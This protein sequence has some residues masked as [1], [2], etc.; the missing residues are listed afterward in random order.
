MEWVPAWRPGG[1]ARRADAPAAGGSNP[2]RAPGALLSVALRPSWDRL[3][4]SCSI[5]LEH[6]FA[7]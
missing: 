4:Q 6:H 5:L 7:W 1:L 3:F 2:A